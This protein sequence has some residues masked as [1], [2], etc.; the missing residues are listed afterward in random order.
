MTAFTGEKPVAVVTGGARRVGLA[1]ARTLAA[2]GFDLVLTY[3]RSQAEA[4]AVQAELAGRG[5]TVRLEALELS[6]LAAVAEQG[7]KLAADL[8]RVDVLVH[9]ASSYAPSPLASLTPA[10]LQDAYAVNAAAPA[11]LTALLAAQL[12]ASG[13]PGG[14]AVIA[15]VDMHV[16]GRPR[17]DMLAYSMSKAA[18]VEMVR[19]TARE[20]APQVRVNGIAP[21]VIAWPEQ[22]RDSDQASQEAY[23]RRVPLQRAGTPEDAAEVVRWLALDAHYVTGE[24]IRVDGGRWLA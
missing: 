24:I 17:K 14:G 6:D 15:M 21:G 20:L 10:Q 8:P 4:E 16:L 12:R 7:A 13:L 22:G 5:S 3:A 19:T 9:N 2:A 11:L 23:L 1:I 18:L